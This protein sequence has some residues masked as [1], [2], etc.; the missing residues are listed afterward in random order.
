MAVI[1]YYV[2]GFLK[3]NYGEYLVWRN[4]QTARFKSEDYYVSTIPPFS[5]ALLAS[6]RKGLCVEPNATFWSQGQDHLG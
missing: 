3:E 4:N 2:G 1:F 5:I 6:L